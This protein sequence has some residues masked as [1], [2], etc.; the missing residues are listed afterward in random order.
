MQKAKPRHNPPRRSA[1]TS[2]A[3]HGLAK[4]MQ[5]HEHSILETEGAR[6]SPP[7]LSVEPGGM[8]FVD[9]EVTV[10]SGEQALDDADELSERCEVAVHRVE[11]LDRDE[12]LR[13]PRSETGP[14]PVLEEGE[15]V[16]FQVCRIVVL[17]GTSVRRGYPRVPHPVVGRGVDELVVQH[18]I[19]ARR[20]ARKQSGVGVEAAV[21]QE[22]GLAPEELGQPPFEGE[23][24]RGVAI[25]QARRCGAV[26]PRPWWWWWWWWWSEEGIVA[27]AAFLRQSA[28]T[29]ARGPIHVLGRQDGESAPE[30]LLEDR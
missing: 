2:R 17:E 7:V 8:G 28:R 3:S 5:P 9:D 18:H 15:D 13:L 26:L 20:E 1:L 24:G 21:E 23:V 6:E 4:S 22:P 27:M 29:R 30:V 14:V 19:A 16:A 10:A 25:E 12:Q 11:R